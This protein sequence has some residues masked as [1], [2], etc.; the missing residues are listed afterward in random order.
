MELGGRGLEH[1]VGGS[2][3]SGWAKLGDG[4]WKGRGW[5]PGWAGPGVGVGRAGGGAW[6]WVGGAWSPFPTQAKPEARL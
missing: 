4:A 5:R 1:R 3:E 6:S 2:L